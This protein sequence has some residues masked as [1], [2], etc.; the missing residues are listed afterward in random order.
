MGRAGKSFFC[1]WWCLLGFSYTCRRVKNPQGATQLGEQHIL[2]AAL[3]LSQEQGHAF[4]CH[5]SRPHSNAAPE[6]T[7]HS[8]CWSDTEPTAE[9]LKHGTG[10]WE[11]S[12]H[13]LPLL[14][15]LQHWHSGHTRYILSRG[16]REKACVGTK[17][18][19]AVLNRAVPK[20]IAAPEF[21]LSEEDKLGWG[22]IQATHYSHLL[23]T[24]GLCL[25]WK[26][27]L[28][29]SLPTLGRKELVNTGTS[30]T[31]GTTVLACKE[32]SSGFPSQ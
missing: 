12:W 27:W 4:P 22:G 1:G 5:L 28:F 9:P 8:N 15:L 16:C 24:P 13:I 19:R 20:E 10:T 17:M 3:I 23:G 2:G 14:A 21:L 29:F 11:N 18:M 30:L 7:H 31:T 32:T 26:L 25:I 6:V